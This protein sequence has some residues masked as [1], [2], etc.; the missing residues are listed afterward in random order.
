MDEKKMVYWLHDVCQLREQVRV[1]GVGRRGPR[2]CLRTRAARECHAETRA[3]ALTA[4]M[5]PCDCTGGQEGD[6]G[7]GRE[8]HKNGGDL[9]PAPPPRPDLRRVPGVGGIQTVY[10]KAQISREQSVPCHQGCTAIAIV[11]CARDLKFET[12]CHAHPSARAVTLSG[13]VNT[14]R[15]E[16]VRERASTRAAAVKEGLITPHLCILF[17]DLCRVLNTC[18]ELHHVPEI[19]A[20]HRQVEQLSCVVAEL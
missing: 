9:R 2:D 13:C 3:H 16:G 14:P 8:G 1:F 15:T 11:R 4:A 6:R 17:D 12:R 10:I 7:V 5:G 18:V 19:T 20:V